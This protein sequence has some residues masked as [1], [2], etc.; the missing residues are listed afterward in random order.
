MTGEVFAAISSRITDILTVFDTEGIRKRYPEPS[1]NANIPTYVDHSLIFMVTDADNVV[2]GQ[3]G[4]ELNVKAVVGD[5]LRW[6]EANI[7]L[8]FEDTALFYR[9]LATAGGNLISTPTPLLAEADLPVPNP[10]DPLHPKVQKVQNHFWNSV[11]LA[12]GAVTYRFY[13]MLVNRDGSIHGYYQW[14]PYI[15]I[16]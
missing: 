3:G 13:F 11:V 14:D 4:A 12:K 8:G 6:R 7:S 5:T 16:S 10:L 9:F 1:K 15:T 2:K